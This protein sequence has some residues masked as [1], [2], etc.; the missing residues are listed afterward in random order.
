MPQVLTYEVESIID[1]SHFHKDVKFISAT[2]TITGGT[3]F[4]CD[5]AGGAFTITL[6]SVATYK[7]R[8]ITVKRV[9]ASNTVT[10]DGAGAETIDGAATYDLTSQ[11]EQV[12]IFS[13]GDEWHII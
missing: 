13:D 12:T 5:A 2:H 11:Y 6:P 7:N 3:V 8:I 1:Q 10:V 4:V 9:S